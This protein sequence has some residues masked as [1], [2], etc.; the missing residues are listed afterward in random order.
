M[1]CANLWSTKGCVGCVWRT[2]WLTEWNSLG[3]PM[4]LNIIYGLFLRQ[5]LVIVNLRVFVII[6]SC[7]LI[8]KRINENASDINKTTDC[9][10]KEKGQVQEDISQIRLQ[11]ERLSLNLPAA[12]LST[13]YLRATEQRY[14]PAYFTYLYRWKFFYTPNNRSLSGC[15]IKL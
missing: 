8:R 5:I 2:D 14:Q 4:Q 10:L 15:P 7:A 3:W 11:S 9:A 6:D 12:V 1:D 13:I